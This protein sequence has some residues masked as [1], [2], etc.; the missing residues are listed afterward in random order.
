MRALV[1]DPEPDLREVPDPVPGEEEAV[2]RVLMAGI[3]GTDLELLAGYKD[4][5][6]IP[7]HEMVG[8]VERTPDPSWQGARVVPEINLACGECLLC[9]EGHRKHCENRRVLGLIGRPGA[10]AEKVTVP[11]E[12]LHVVPDSIT[13]EEAVWTEPLAAALGVWDAG[14]QE[15]DPVLVLGDGRLGALTAMGLEWRGARTEVVG[16]DTE[17]LRI[18]ESMGVTVNR[19]GSRPIYPW[20]VEASGSVYGIQSALDWVRPMGTIVLKST[21]R[22]PST[23]DLARIVVDEIRLVGSRCGSF[24]PAIDALRCGELPVKRLISKIFPFDEARE[25][26]RESTRPGVFTVLLDF[27]R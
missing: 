3:C 6:G 22:D 18:L 11:L 1:V 25:A 20:V 19:R 4:F 17:K 24:P 27:R 14:I 23:I 9:R 7:G 10:F 26:L 13:D 5:R 15:G 21:C 16:K 12:N 8:V 2:V